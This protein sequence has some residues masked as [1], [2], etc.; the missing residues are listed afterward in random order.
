[1][2]HNVNKLILASAISA[3]MLG[4]SSYAS[5]GNAT[6]SSASATTTNGSYAASNAIDGS[7]ST[8]WEATDTTSSL[9]INLAS[10]QKIDDITINWYG[11]NSYT[12]KI[13]VS[14]DGGS[15]WTNVS[16]TSASGSSYNKNIT[17]QAVNAIRVSG[18]GSTL[19]INEISASTLGSATCSTSS[20]TST[21]TP[22]TKATSTPTATTKATATPTTAATATPTSKATATPTTAATATPTNKATATPTTAATA[23]PTPT[24]STSATYP[25]DVVGGLS[26]WHLTLPISSSNAQYPADEIKMTSSTPLSKYSGTY[27]KLNS[28]NDAIVMTA[29]FGGATTSSGTAYART[30]LRERDASYTAAAWSCKTAVRSMTFT[31]RVTK[32]PTAKPEMSMGQIHDGDSDNLEVQYIGPSSANGSTDTGTIIASFNGG[33]SKLTLDS[34]YTIGQKVTVTIYTKGDG[35]MYVDYKNLSTGLTKTQSAAFG[36]V[37]GSCYFK[38]GNYHQACSKTNIYGGTNSTCAN[39]GWASSKYETDPWGTSVQELYSVSLK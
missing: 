33:G 27:F 29:L 2:K 8:R 23:T 15:T 24:S 38:V 18:N 17:D 35:V 13:D 20:A 32:S 4:V 19:R 36:T 22:T 34:A 1:M 14:K 21:P 11:S 28:S 6:L 3:M 25:A 16:S 30:E 26:L 9:T 5:A 39:K 10:C 12:H 31:S 7:S 37:V